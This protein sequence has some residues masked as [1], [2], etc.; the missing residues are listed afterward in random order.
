MTAMH[1]ASVQTAF[2]PA[3]MTPGLIIETPGFHAPSRMAASA[4][5]T[6]AGPPPTTRTARMSAPPKCHYTERCGAP[7]RQ[8]FWIAVDSSPKC[9]HGRIARFPGRTAYW[10]IMRRSLEA[11]ILDSGGQQPEMLARA[12]RALSRTH[13]LLGNH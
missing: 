8:R 13:S 7:L 3:R 10:G 2:L 6:P 9:W 1:T 4:A 11:E 12:H 5:I